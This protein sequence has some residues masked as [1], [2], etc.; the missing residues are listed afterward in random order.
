MIHLE[1]R[2]GIFLDI[3][4]IVLS[5]LLKNVLRPAE[6]KDSRMLACNMRRNVFVVPVTEVLEKQTIAL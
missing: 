1:Q 5:K 3:N 2:A 4:L 6:K